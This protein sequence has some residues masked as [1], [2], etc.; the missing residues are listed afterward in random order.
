[1][2]LLL[3]WSFCSAREAQYSSAHSR[4]IAK[5]FV[6]GRRLFN[7]HL[8]TIYDIDATLDVFY[9]HYAAAIEVINC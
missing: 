2:P 4:P 8:L 6:D 5:D 3:L 7:H 1:M 9:I